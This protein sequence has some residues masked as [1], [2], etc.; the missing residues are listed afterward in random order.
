MKFAEHLPGWP[1]AYGDW[2]NRARPQ[3]EAA[4][5]GEAF[6][7]YPWVEP[8]ET[9]FSPFTGALAEARLAVLT[10]GGFYLPDSQQ[11]FTAEHIEGD[12]TFRVLPP[13]VT[14]GDLG[15]AHTHFPHEAALADLNTV[16]P[17]E[18]LREVVAEGRIGSLGPTYSISGYC[19]DVA[20]LCEQS[21]ERIA[22]HAQEAGCHAALLVPV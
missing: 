12:P 19:T 16:L 6:A 15:I 7:G 9:P 13:T 22:Q 10:T 8:S 14:P 18:H 1:E 4:Q 17:L 21:A 2:L 20:A 11:P 3:L 5:W